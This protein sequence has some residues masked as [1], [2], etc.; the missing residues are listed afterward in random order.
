M[1]LGAGG[2]PGGGDKPQWL[3]LK[4]K[5]VAAEEMLQE[6]GGE[7][8][9]FLVRGH[10]DPSKYVVSVMFKGQPTHH[11]VAP[12]EEGLMVVNKRMYW[13]CVVVQHDNTDV[14]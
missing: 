3:R 14:A 6:L 13:L 1:G 5:R 9:C 2:P 7:D 12:N 10:K 4:T 8:G 11:L